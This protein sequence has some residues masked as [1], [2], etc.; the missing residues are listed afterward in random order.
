MAEIKIYKTTVCPYCVKAKALLNKKGVAEQ[1]T[2]ID[3]T[4]DPSLKEEM[5]SLSG[6]RMTVPQIF[7]DGQH[8]G[9]CDDL[10]A[11]ES[12][13]KLDQLLS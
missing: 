10:Y 9:G 3:I 11:L 12:E 1:I 13:G 2:E 7:I 5:V 8:V 6:G 4:T